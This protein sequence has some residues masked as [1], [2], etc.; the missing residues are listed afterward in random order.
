MAS[1]INLKEIQCNNNVLTEL[2]VE[3]LD[4]IEIIN[5]D[6]NE[7]TTLKTDALTKLR[8]LSANNNFIARINLTAAKDLERISVNDNKLTWL[9]L[10]TLTG[11][12]HIECS[13]IIEPDNNKL[14][15]TTL[16]LPENI[17]SIPISNKILHPQDTIGR[18][19]FDLIDGDYFSQGIKIDLSDYMY[20]DAESHKTYFT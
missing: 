2:K 3:L 7:L 15:F 9:N 19:Q 20:P 16:M 4:N 17:G 5:C 12:S 8:L 18:E 6:N 14:N 11:V 10:S 1:L 13:N